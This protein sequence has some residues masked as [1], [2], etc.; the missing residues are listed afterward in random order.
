MGAYPQ[1]DQQKLPFSTP[2]SMMG[3]MMQQ[4]SYV[5]LNQ[6][7]Q[8]QQQ[9]IPQHY[10]QTGNHP[11]YPGAPQAQS[12][13]QPYGPY[14]ATGMQ[15]QPGRPP[16]HVAYGHSP[17]EQSGYVLKVKFIM[18]FVKRKLIVILMNFVVMGSMCQIHQQQ[19]ICLQINNSLHIILHRLN[20]VI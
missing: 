20:K 14:S 15:H 5:G 8:P 16:Q 17:L 4:P 19:V 12:G 7:P 6:Q 18:K 2:Q 9:R 1:Q 11:M 13:A 3:G 10:S